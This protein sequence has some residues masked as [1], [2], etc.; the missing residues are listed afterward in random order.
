M[1]E[2]EGLVCSL[3]EVLATSST[4]HIVVRW[5]QD[6]AYL[7]CNLPHG[8]NSDVNNV[9]VSIRE[10]RG[11]IRGESALR[12]GEGGIGYDTMPATRVNVCIACSHV[13]SQACFEAVDL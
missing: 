2:G 10:I 4:L 12:G 5:P 8:N 1:G 7:E 3:S 11:A 9:R 13:R 6:V